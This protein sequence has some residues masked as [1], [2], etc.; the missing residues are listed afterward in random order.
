M[1]L[2]LPEGFDPEAVEFRSH[3]KAKACWNRAVTAR[4][5]D[6]TITILEEIGENWDG[7]GVTPNRISA[8]L[9]KIGDRPVTVVINSPGGDLFDGLAIF[10]LL[11]N[12]SQ[13]IT[14][15]IVGVAGSA[16]SIIAMAGDEVQIAKAGML[17]IHNSQWVAIGDKKVM[18]QAHNDMA[19]FDEVI[20]VAYNDRTDLALAEIH[21]MMDA[22]TFIKGED[23]VEQGFCDR[24]LP[25]DE[26]T[27]AENLAPK[28]AAFKIDELLAKGKSVPRAER[29]ALIKEITEGTPRATF[30][31]TPRA[32][33][34]ELD[35]LAHLRAAAM[36]LSLNRA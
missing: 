6:Q 30:G 26:V 31:V 9:A 2:K 7:S 32:D 15:Q 17:F 21:A 22:E 18:L 23:A 4:S 3:P 11:K 8:A 19:V 27:E 28:T 34:T 24:L 5:D 35:G 33:E 36:K 14:V 12:H 1:N 20:A 13:P 16:A 25:A 10:N 29:R